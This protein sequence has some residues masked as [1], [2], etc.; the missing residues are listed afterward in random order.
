MIY[1]IYMSY[2]AALSIFNNVK[3]IEPVVEIRH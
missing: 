3:K 2:D 1:M